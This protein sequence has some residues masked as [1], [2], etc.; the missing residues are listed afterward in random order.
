LRLGVDTRGRLNTGGDINFRQNKVNFFAS[1]SY[2]QRKSLGVSDAN[3]KFIGT[4]PMGVV[5]TSNNTNNGYFAFFRGG[6][7]YFV[8]NRNTISITANFNKG[9]FDNDGTQQIDTTT[10][11]LISMSNRNTLSSFNFKNFGGQLSFKHNFAKMGIVF[12][13]MQII[14]LVLIPMKPIL[15]MQFIIPTDHKNTH[16]TSKE[17]MVMVQISSLLFKQIMKIN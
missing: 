1:G 8:D 10:T 5:S 15:V 13:P 17:A 7:D 6:L 2:N 16:Y 9:K 11:S 12:L 14:I 3:T 4:S